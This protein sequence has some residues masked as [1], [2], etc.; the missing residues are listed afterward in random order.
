[1]ASETVKK[2]LAAEAESEKQNALA[3]QK[4][5]EIINEAQRKAAITVQKRLSDANTE[6]ARLR[7]EGRKKA[8]DHA[9]RAQEE[10]QRSLDEI[11]RTA[12]DNSDK[13]VQA[14]IDGFFA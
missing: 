14:V 10:C 2:I 8:A 3:R 12:R 13:A 4:A 6:A 1:M 9:A 11:R 5:E 7:E